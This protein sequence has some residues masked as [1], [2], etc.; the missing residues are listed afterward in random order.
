MIVGQVDAHRLADRQ[1][2][3]AGVDALPVVIEAGTAPNPGG[4]P[5]GK[6][7]RV[8]LTNDHLGY[9]LT[10]YVLAVALVVIYVL[11]QRSARP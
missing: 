10:W 2:A 8:N 4:L 6:A 7:M 3:F 9:A 5:I 11:S 1:A